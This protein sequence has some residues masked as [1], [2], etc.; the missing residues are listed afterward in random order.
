MNI[1]LF[2]SGLGIGYLI[3]FMLMLFY[4][5]FTRNKSDDWNKQTIQLMK[6]RN[7]TDSQLLSAFLSLIDT[8]TGEALNSIRMYDT[9]REEVY[10]EHL[11]KKLS[12]EST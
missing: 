6:E 2:I 7:E 12:Q 9:K 5:Q 4:I 3:S 11:G 10:K 1:L 8:K